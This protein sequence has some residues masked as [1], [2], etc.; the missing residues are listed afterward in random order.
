MKTVNIATN[1]HHTACQPRRVPGTRTTH[2]GNR[3]RPR[4]GQ[5]NRHR[6]QRCRNRPRFPSKLFSTT[7]PKFQLTEAC[8]VPVLVFSLPLA[9]MRPRSQRLGGESSLVEAKVKVMLPSS[10]LIPVTLG[11]TP[12]PDDV[13]K[14]LWK[15]R[16]PLPVTST[17]P[18]SSVSLSLDSSTVVVLSSSS[19]VPDSYSEKVED[20]GITA[21]INRSARPYDTVVYVAVDKVYERTG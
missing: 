15:S 2:G 7:I 8:A 18:L 6:Q 13:A 1:F 16:L 4:W 19:G 21:E 20:R 3:A 5:R 10:V 11:R 14:T 9:E 12:A 17:Q